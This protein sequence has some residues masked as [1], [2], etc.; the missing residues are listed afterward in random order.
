MRFLPILFVL[1]AVSSSHAREILDGAN[2]RLGDDSFVARFGRPP[3]TGDPES[4][5]MKAHLAY[6]H[7]LL[8]E[9]SATRPELAAQRA[10]LLDYLAE[11][12]DA[13]TTPIN[14]RLPW[15]TPVFIDD[16]GNICAVGYLIERSVG[17]E[18]AER[19]ASAYRFSYLEDI[20]AAMPEVR[21]WIDAS[22]FTLDELAS[23]QPGYEGA[24]LPWVE[25]WETWTAE[26]RPRKHGRYN[27]ENV[28][29]RFRDRMMQGTWKKT[30]QDG[31]LIGRGSFH[32]GAGT[33]RTFYPDGKL[34]AI[35][36]FEGNRPNGTW[37]LYHPSGNLAAEGT[38]SRGQRHGAWTFYY[39]TKQRT[40]ISKGRFVRGSYAKGAYV[41]E[42]RH[43]KTDGSLLATARQR[44]ESLRVAFATRGK[45]RHDVIAGNGDA[46]VDVFTR[47]KA[48]LYRSVDTF[49]DEAGRQVR[50]EGDHWL[51]SECAWTPE[52]QRAFR[53]GH[54][55]TVRASIGSQNCSEDRAVSAARNKQLDR[56][57][58]ASMAHY[59][60]TPK[61]LKDLL[62]LGLTVDSETEAPADL[63]DLLASGHHGGIR[64]PHVN[65]LFMDLYATLPGYSHPMLCPSDCSRFRL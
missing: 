64:W 19:I 46:R 65:L 30:D 50:R 23:I 18:V 40:V 42:W 37:K 20:A 48:R 17:R 14:T 44:G 34:L 38:M 15:R 2:H 63:S 39:D 1:A 47:G 16:A 27:H 51:A 57:F 59:V 61:Y 24:E 43:F 21:A 6:V 41:G 35:G 8:A 49:Y 26:S 25:Q 36:P 53:N 55:W 13:G 7:E 29:G 56:L 58:V 5:R 28:T 60:S 54:L 22:G 11:Y 32:D 62:A 12:R 4:T 31:K 9:R 52:I 3:D 10:R 33:W 45:I